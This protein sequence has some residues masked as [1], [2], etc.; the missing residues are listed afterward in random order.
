MLTALTWTHPVHGLVTELLCPTHEPPARQA[1]TELG[2]HYTAR[3]VDH[4]RCHRCDGVRPWQGPQRPNGQAGQAPASPDGGGSC[5]PADAGW[6]QAGPRITTI[7][8][9][10]Q[11]S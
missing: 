10:T 8:R 6:F 4:G 9:L 3:P 5:A 2:I 11:R 7:L 1:F